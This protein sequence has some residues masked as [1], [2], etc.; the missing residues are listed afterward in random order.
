MLRRVAFFPSGGGAGFL[1]VLFAGFL[2][3]HCGPYT[4]IVVTGSLFITAYL[5]PIDADND[6]HVVPTGTH[7]ARQKFAVAV[8]L[9]FALVRCS[10]SKSLALETH[11][12]RCVVLSAL[13]GGWLASDGVAQFIGPIAV[14]STRPFSRSSAAALLRSGV[15]TRTRRRSRMSCGLPTSLV[16]AASA[17]SRCAGASR[18]TT[19][20]VPTHSSDHWKSNCQRCRPARRCRR[21]R[22]ACDSCS[23]AVSTV[24]S[25]TAF[26]TECG[27]AMPSEDASPYVS[28]LQKSSVTM[29]SKSQAPER[30]Q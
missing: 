26:C 23:R 4:H 18:A 27:K 19:A 17:S 29:N 2:T 16:L 25:G 13:P 9:L 11:R 22:S 30:W 12:M 1:C 28:I 6:L 8:V 10:I 7:R 24:P 3:I 21:P 14:R 20:W 15:W 5:P